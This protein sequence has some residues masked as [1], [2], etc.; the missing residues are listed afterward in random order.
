MVSNSTHSTI[1]TFSYSATSPSSPNSTSSLG[2]LVGLPIFFVALLLVGIAVFL[3]FRHRKSMDIELSNKLKSQ[4][5]SHNGDSRESP[6]SGYTGGLQ[7]APQSPIYENF[8]G[9]QSD[10]HKFQSAVQS[11]NTHR[12]H[13]AYVQCDPHDA[14]YSNDPALFNPDGAEIS[15]DVYIMPDA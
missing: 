2:L 1:A 11:E 8:Q 13:Q 10:L 14:I 6:Y 15:E 9:G 5:K 3:W 12:D 4:D 7:P